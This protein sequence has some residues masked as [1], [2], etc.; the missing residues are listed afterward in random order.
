M[1]LRFRDNLGAIRV[2]NS[3]LKVRPEIDLKIDKE[4]DVTVY[5]SPPGEAKIRG[6]TLVLAG[7][8]ISLDGGG[9]IRVNEF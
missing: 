7:G 2:N 8:E 6:T 5:F 3:R 9:L 1:G 4:I